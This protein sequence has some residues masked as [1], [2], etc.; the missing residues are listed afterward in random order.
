MAALKLPAGPAELL[1]LTRPPLGQ[2]LGGEH[3]LC[4]GGGTALAARWHHRHSTDIDYFIKSEPYALLY[5][6]VDPFSRDLNRAT[7]GL[8]ELTTGPA[9]ARIIL[10]DGGEIS[11]ST[12]PGFTGNPRSDDTVRGTQISLETS[13][14]I[15]A[16]KIG[17]RILGNNTFV[18]RDLYDIAVAQHYEP[19][20]LPRALQ[21]FS[22]DQLADI[23]AELRSLPR[24]FMTTHPQRLLAPARPGAAA[25]AV[26]MVRSI[27][28]PS[29]T[30]HWQ[31]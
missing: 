6:N 1:E 28:Q 21:P 8:R 23:R 24:D 17:G 27:L 12:T 30:Y 9:F 5:A 4:L 11:V 26:S 3:H 14:E 29:R 2:H 10:A 31:R 13:A 18:P 19:E 22:P 20:A 16:R 7:G 15:L 25:Y